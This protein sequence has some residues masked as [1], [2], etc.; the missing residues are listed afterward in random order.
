MRA[1]QNAAVRNVEVRSAVAVAA[2]F[3]FHFAQLEFVLLFEVQRYSSLWVEQDSGDRRFVRSLAEL[4]VG[5][6]LPEAEPQ[7]CFL[8]VEPAVV[9]FLFAELPSCTPVAA[10]VV[11][12]FAEQLFR[13][14]LKQE[15]ILYYWT[16]Y[17][18]LYLRVLTRDDKRAIRCYLCLRS[19]YPKHW[20]RASAEP[21]YPYISEPR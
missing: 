15:L 2:P 16:T 20:L 18:Y 6:F 8:V 19:Y 14:C 10:G 7:V 1:L 11:F 4:P 9:V 5:R 17:L 21:F 3:Y 12:L 13:Y